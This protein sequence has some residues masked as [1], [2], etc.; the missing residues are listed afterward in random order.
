MWAASRPRSVT[1][2]VASDSARAIGM[3]GSLPWLTGVARARECRLQLGFDHRLDELAHPVAQASFDRIKPAVEKRDR[4]RGFRLPGRRIRAIVNHGV[5]S[6]GAQ[7][8]GLLGFQ[9]PETTPSS[10]PTTLRTAPLPRGTSFRCAGLSETQFW[11]VAAGVALT[12]MLTLLIADGI[13]WFLRR[14][15]WRRQ[16]VEPQ[17]GREPARDEPERE[18]PSG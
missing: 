16:E 5:V 14:T 18:A 10:I 2:P 1:V 12:P 15:L 11:L 13:G 9:H 7:T 6:T 3:L 17:S 8:P 4:R